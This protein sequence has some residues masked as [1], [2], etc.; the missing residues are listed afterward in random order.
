M[1]EINAQMEIIKA[2][3]AAAIAM[4]EQSKK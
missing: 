4:A 3:E 1:G 2:E